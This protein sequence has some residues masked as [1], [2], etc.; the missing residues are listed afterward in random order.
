M[1]VFVANSLRGAYVRSAIGLGVSFSLNRCVDGRVTIRICNLYTMFAFGAG[2]CLAGDM[3][4]CF[5]L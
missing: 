3:S 4:V 2:C 1:L 5:C